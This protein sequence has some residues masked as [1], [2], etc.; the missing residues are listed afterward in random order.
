MTVIVGGNARGIGKTTT[1]CQIIATFP[2][3]GWTGVKVTGHSGHSRPGTHPA[4]ERF[5]AAG[6]RDPRKHQKALS[7]RLA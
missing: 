3:A 7:P 2:E 1:V 4:T 6:A 5:T